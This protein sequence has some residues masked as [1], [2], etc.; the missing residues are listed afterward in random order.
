MLLLLLLLLLLEEKKRKKR[1]E[2]LRTGPAFTAHRLTS[3]GKIQDKCKAMTASMKS[4]LDKLAA[5]VEELKGEIEKGNLSGTDQVIKQ[6]QSTAQHCKELGASWCKVVTL[7]DADLTPSTE[8]TENTK[9]NHVHVPADVQSAEAGLRSM[10]DQAGPVV[11]DGSKLHTLAFFEWSHKL[12]AASNDI[13]FIETTVSELK[14]LYGP[15]DHLI[16][17]FV[18]LGADVGNYIKQKQ[19]QAQRDETNKKRE[20]ERKMVQDARATAR[21]HADEIKSGAKAQHTIFSI[22]KE[23]WTDIKVV[24]PGFKADDHVAIPWLI[25]K[26]TAAST[27]RNSA[28]VSIKLAEFAAGYK[29]T[30]SFKVDGRAQAT[31]QASQGKEESIRMMSTVFD[32]T[33]LDVSAVDG[34]KDVLSLVW[35][36]GYDPRISGCW[37][38]PNGCAMLKSMVMGEIYFVA[39][40]LSIVL[41]FMKKQNID[42]TCD[43]M[44]TFLLSL[45]K[46]SEELAKLEGVAGSMCQDDVLF[47]PQGWIACERSNSTVM[48]YGI[49]KS[50]MLPGETNQRSY[51]GAV[52]LLKNSGR[53]ST[54]MEALLKC[55]EA[56]G[57]ET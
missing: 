14:D 13:E 48:C 21:K 25:R 19:R 50:F 28:N 26:S 46:D 51:Q 34:A 35:F 53:N 54:K 4:G 43:S 6:Y 23:A 18:K 7:T 56:T 31:M 37:L 36:W 49:R 10:V 42:A 57:P 40:R 9:E 15:V 24:E 5:A 38:P 8:S 52:T 20:Q 1:L 27:W 32:P 16:R 39:F 55:Y 3:A 11:K 47:L 30:E 45:T 29:R 33:P 41:D 44:R 2:K 22:P 17:G 12:V